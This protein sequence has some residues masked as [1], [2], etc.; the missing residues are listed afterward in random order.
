MSRALDLPDAGIWRRRAEWFWQAHDAN[1]GPAPLTLDPRGE[2]L[3]ADLEI[4]FCAGA[5]AA[6][7]LL[8]WALV[9]GVARDRAAE[10][11]AWA[12]PPDLDWLRARRNLWAHGAGGPVDGPSQADAEGAVRT[13]FRQIFAAAWR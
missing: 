1:A 8:A 5:W 13:A 9:E 4:A 7:I 11:P 3:L 6:V 2:A 10:T 12:V